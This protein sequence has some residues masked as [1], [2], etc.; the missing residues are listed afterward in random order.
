MGRLASQVVCPKEI[1]S[2]FLAYRG[3]GG[4]MSYEQIEKAFDLKPT[5]GMTAYRIVQ[6]AKKKTNGNGNGHELRTQPRQD[7]RRKSPKMNM[8]AV[9]ILM[10]RPPTQ[11]KA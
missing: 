10:W 6:K 8:S 4:D 3:N 11:R 2:I 7:S 9:D 5:R 1:R